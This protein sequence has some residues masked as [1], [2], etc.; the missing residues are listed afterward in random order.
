M[1]V[2][3][4]VTENPAS[5]ILLSTPVLNLATRQVCTVISETGQY[6]SV[7]P[8][9][10][11]TPMGGYFKSC[12]LKY[13]HFHLCGTAQG[14]SYINQMH[15]LQ[16]HHESLPKMIISVSSVSG[17]QCQSMGISDFTG[18]DTTSVLHKYVLAQNMYFSVHIWVTE[19]YFRV[20][21]Y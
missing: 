8:K 14:Y 9:F 6:R 20:L 12:T 5:L 2:D 4:T 21:S 1:R 13:Y 7:L 11:F 17:L 3:A 19:P 18:A 15:I 10:C 16:E